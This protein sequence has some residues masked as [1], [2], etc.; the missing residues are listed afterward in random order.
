MNRRALLAFLGG[1]VA[2]AVAACSSAPQPAATGSGSTGTGSA[3][4]GSSGTGSATFARTT[5]FTA[6]QG[7]VRSP[8]PH[9][10][11]G[12]L[13]GKGNNLALTIDDGTNPEVLAAYAQL[14]KETGLRATFFC[15]GINR[16]WTEQAPALRKLLEENQIFIA[17]HTWSHPDLRKLSSTALATEVQHNEAFLKN[18]FGVTGRPFLR[19]PF[20]FH[21]KRIDA[22]LDSLGYPA[23]TMWLGTLGDA[24]VQP[25][26]VIV[27]QAEQWFLPEHIVIGHANHPPVIGVMD[28]LMSIIHE[29]K[30]QPVH[31]GDVYEV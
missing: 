3:E 10:T 11:I 2:S 9:G 31:F 6:P 26:E 28:Q 23:V 29:R 25:P 18:T 5:R 22:Q 13:P 8:V 7:I 24:K 12:K 27:Q 1:A 19:P 15:N 21:N 4:T 16:S 14:C 20:G 17:N 30:L